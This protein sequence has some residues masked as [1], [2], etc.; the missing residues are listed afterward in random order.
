MNRNIDT[1]PAS[2]L[3]AFAVVL[4]CLARV[5]GTERTEPAK[6]K[7]QEAK[8]P[9]ARSKME[10]NGSGDFAASVPEFQ[11]KDPIGE[12]H[13]GAS[14]FS[15]TGMLIMVTVPNL[16]Q[17]EKQKRWEKW[18][19]KQTWPQANAPRRV[20]LE[21]LSQQETF[22]EKVRTLMAEKYDPRGDMTVLV[23]EDGKVRRS[24]G[25]QNNETV[26]LLVDASGK[27][28]HHESDFVE[29]EMESARRVVGQ[30][31]ELAESV[32]PALVPLANNKLII[33][34]MVPVTKN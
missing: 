24:F 29:P 18:L 7:L 16:T 22:K 12:A 9:A 23:D 19:S 33:A 21:D 8:K 17:Y 2:L 14:L 10:A 6:V 31:R 28:V 30:V 3:I 32:R 25:V 4:L 27:I 1:C 34:D 20:L 5:M 11:L 26:I 13:S 15:S